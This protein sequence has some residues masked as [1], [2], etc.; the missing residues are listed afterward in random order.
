MAAVPVDDGAQGLLT[1]GV[2]HLLVE[3]LHFDQAAV[4]SPDNRAGRSEL[5]PAAAAA[6]KEAS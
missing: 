3:D 5:Y 2:P 1:G 4:A 6:V